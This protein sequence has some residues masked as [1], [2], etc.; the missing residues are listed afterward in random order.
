MENSKLDD[1]SKGATCGY[2][3]LKQVVTMLMVFS[4]SVRQVIP[5]I[6]SNDTQGTPNINFGNG[7]KKRETVEETYVGD[8]TLWEPPDHAKATYRAARRVKKEV[9]ESRI[10]N[11][12]MRFLRTVGLREIQEENEARRKKRSIVPRVSYPFTIDAESKK[13]ISFVPR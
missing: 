6:R 13:K 5:I 3:K 2:F 10:L 11:K 4:F 9:R 1:R 8:P 7:R 12:K